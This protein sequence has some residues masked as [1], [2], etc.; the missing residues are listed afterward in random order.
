MNK[1]GFQDVAIVILTIVVLFMIAPIF[2]K[3][4]N[5]LDSGLINATNVST[6]SPMAASNVAYIDTT[7]NNF[8]DFFTI[9][10]FVIAVAILFISAFFVDMHP[11]FFAIYI[12]FAILMTLLAAGLSD[13]LTKMYA[14]GQV[15]QQLLHMPYTVWF[16]NHIMIVCLMIIFFTAIIM[17]GKMRVSS[18]RTL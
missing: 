3:V 17:Y 16:A 12:F 10:C 7:F 1:K 8:W 13:L 18:T 4:I 2:L 5:T 11:I 6:I 14:S 15:T 9:M